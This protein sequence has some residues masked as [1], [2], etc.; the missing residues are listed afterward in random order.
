M[1]ML[2]FY[3]IANKKNEVTTRK[4]NFA[5]I[6]DLKAIIEQNVL[7]KKKITLLEEQRDVLLEYADRLNE[8][9]KLK[10]IQKGFE[11]GFEKLNK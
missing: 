8:L 5:L 3:I 9:N 6:D 1:G 7:L 4:L 2:V 11:K 10:K